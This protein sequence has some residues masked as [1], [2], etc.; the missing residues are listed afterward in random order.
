MDQVI[1]E[2][3]NCVSNLNQIFMLM[4]TTFIP[5]KLLSI[6]FIANASDH[7]PSARF[8]LS[9]TSVLIFPLLIPLSRPSNNR[10]PYTPLS[11]FMNLYTHLLVWGNIII[12]ALPSI[13]GFVYWRTTD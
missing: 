8:Y 11:S 3:K 4:L 7:A 9:F 10:T 5:S 1:R 2:S 6:V 13:I 12:L